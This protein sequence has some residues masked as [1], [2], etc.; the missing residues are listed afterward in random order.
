[1]QG[2]WAYSD[3]QQKLNLSVFLDEP[4]QFSGTPD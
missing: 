4:I 2:E 1:M 3:T